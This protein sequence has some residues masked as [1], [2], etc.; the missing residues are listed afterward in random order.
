MYTSINSN[1]LYICLKTIH[2]LV[3]FCASV[4]YLG[5]LKKKK[6]NATENVNDAIIFY[7]HG[8]RQ[9]TV[10]LGNGKESIVDP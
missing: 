6:K 4:N 10:W 3:S 5:V 9:H 7:A 8:C 2:T 1:T